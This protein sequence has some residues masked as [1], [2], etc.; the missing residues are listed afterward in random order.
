VA[1]LGV[2]FLSASHLHLSSWCYHLGVI[3][4]KV[5][6][7]VHQTTVWFQS[8]CP[9]VCLGVPAIHVRRLSRHFCYV[10]PCVPSWCECP[11]LLS[12]PPCHGVCPGVPACFSMT[13]VVG[14]QSNLVEH[15]IKPVHNTLCLS[16]TPTNSWYFLSWFTLVWLSFCLAFIVIM[17][18][19]VSTSCKSQVE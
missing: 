5:G 7:W 18:L 8:P 1:Y 9:R 15:Y 19:K 17:Y 3:C 2:D 16:L 12:P 11:G 13:H 14:D 10:C 4:M 6:G